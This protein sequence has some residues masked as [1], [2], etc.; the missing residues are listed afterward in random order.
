MDTAREFGTLLHEHGI[1]ALQSEFTREA[2]SRGTRR[3]F[4]CLQSPEGK[5]LAVSD[6]SQWQGIEVSDRRQTAITEKQAVFR[7]FSL[8]GHRFRI[9]SVSVPVGNGE[10]LEIGS[11]LQGEE[12]V[13]ERY[14]ETFG[15]ALIVMLI[16]GGLV[17]RLLAVKAMSGV[18]RITDTASRIGRHDLSRR[19]PLSDEGQE[20]ASLALAFNA[21]LER[22][23]SLLDELHQ[24]TDN[25]AHELRTPLTRIRGIAETTLRGDGKLADYREMTASVI[26]ECDNLVGM[27]STMLEI[28]KTGSGK[29]DLDMTLLDITEIVEEAAD[30]FTPMAEDCGVGIEIVKLIRGM[31]VRGDRV[32]LQRVVGNLLDNA[33]KYT[34]SGGKVRLSADKDGEWVKVEVADTGIG[35]PEQDIP[36]IFD[37]FYRGDKSRSTS[38]SGLG[39]SL[40]LAL[41]RAH[42]G[43][44]TVTPN[45]TGT[46]FSILLPSASIV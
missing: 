35:V 16:C 12:I 32:R 23:Q 37:R 45:A 28:A 36:H 26:D 20:I 39:L 41:V 1:A 27:I 42:G 3:V 9:R 19:V 33:I 13:L 25:V 7:T 29:A 31:T 46:I 14:R 4:F 30:L 24:I 11:T 8:S 22:I 17:G 34:P 21:M 40:A 43:N 10:V 18:Q 6:L 44:I 2:E 5:L 38:G 15:A